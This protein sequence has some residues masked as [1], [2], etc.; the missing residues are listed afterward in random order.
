MHSRHYSVISAKNM[1][2]NNKKNPSSY[3]PQRSIATLARWVRPPGSGHLQFPDIVIHHYTPQHCKLRV[4]P[5]GGAIRQGNEHARWKV[6]G[7]KD[8]MC[9]RSVVRVSHQSTLSKTNAL[10]GETDGNIAICIAAQ[11]HGS[12][13]EGRPG[14]R[15][16]A[17]KQQPHHAEELPEPG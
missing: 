12:V 7:D 6:I 5:E 8:R 1:G 16:L 15:S 4:T 14:L 13:R 3:R 11:S 17:A 9:R 2:S 10:H